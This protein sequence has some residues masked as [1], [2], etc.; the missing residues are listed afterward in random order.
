MG[1]D[2][3]RCNRAPCQLDEMGAG[4]DERFEPSE[5]AVR[6]DAPRRYRDRVAAGTAEHFSFMKD[7]IGLDRLIGHNRAADAQKAASSWRAALRGTENQS[8]EGRGFASLIFISPSQHSSE[9]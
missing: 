7:Q 9:P 8:D 4:T 6:D 1:V 5:G 2:E 3:A